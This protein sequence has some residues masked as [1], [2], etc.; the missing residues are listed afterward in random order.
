MLYQ[1]ALKSHGFKRWPNF[2]LKVSGQLISPGRVL[3]LCG[4][5]NAA[6]KGGFEGSVVKCDGC[7]LQGCLSGHGDL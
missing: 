2:L 3:T 6:L 1:A 4:T 7:T 5:L